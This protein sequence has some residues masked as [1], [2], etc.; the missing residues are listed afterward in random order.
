MKNGEKNISPI[1]ISCVILS[2]AFLFF[3]LLIHFIRTGSCDRIVDSFKLT[4]FNLLTFSLPKISVKE[5]KNKSAQLRTPSKKVLLLEESNISV[6]EDP[7]EIINDKT[8]KSD[9]GDK[10]KRSSRLFDALRTSLNK[11]ERNSSI[12]TS[13]NNHLFI[14]HK[15]VENFEEEALSL[16][17]GVMTKHLIADILIE[18][19]GTSTSNPQ[20]HNSIKPV[21]HTS[22]STNE[23]EEELEVT[24]L[25][26]TEGPSTCL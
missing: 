11:V 24:F 9:D 5:R 19:N 1:I 7:T 25:N 16:L 8:E 3:L 20:L 21:Q 13:S 6:Y 23:S 15:E 2:L 22:H 4:N 17:S 18:G 10:I 26:D 12:L 14:V